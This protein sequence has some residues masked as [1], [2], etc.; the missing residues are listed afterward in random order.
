MDKKKLQFESSIVNITPINPSF[1]RAYCRI[2]Y[3]GRN[4]NGTYISKEA[5]ENAISTLY[6]VP[7]VGEWLKERDNFGGH[8]GKI[9]IHNN[10]VKYIDTTIPYGCV[11]SKEDINWRW[12]TA[13]DGREYF[14]V[15]IFLWIHKF[16]ELQKLVNENSWH[17]MEIDV[18]D[19]Q[20]RMVNGENLYVIEKMEFTALC[21]LGKDLE[22]P[23]NNTE[24]CFEMSEIGVY[25]LNKNKFKREFK[26]MI[27]EL[28]FTLSNETKEIPDYKE[29]MKNNLGFIN[30]NE[31]IIINNSK[32][33]IFCEDFDN[34][35]IE[36]NL[37]NQISK[38]NN[39]NDLL[40]EAYIVIEDDFVKSPL[41]NF[42]CQHH[43]ISGGELVIH[44][45]GLQMAFDYVKQQELIGEP[46]AHLRRHYEELGLDQDNFSEFGLNFEDY[47]KYFAKED[48]EM[49]DVIMSQSPET[50]EMEC[51]E[52]EEMACHEVA[53]PTEYVCNDEKFES[54]ADAKVDK[55]D[56]K[57]DEAEFV[58]NEEVEEDK[59]ESF[60]SDEAKAE[61]ESKAD[62]K[63]SDEKE[64]KTEEDMALKYEKLSLEHSDM[65]AKYGELSLNY[66][67]LK[68]QFSEV[69]GQ[70]KNYELKEKQSAVDAVFAEFFNL[71]TED[72]VKDVKEKA[73]NM[74]VDVLRNQLY[75][76]YGAKMYKFNLHN[77]QNQDV[78]NMGIHPVELQEKSADTESDVFA[79]AKKELENK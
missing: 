21:I 24:P 33:S 64:E 58:K 5:F 16:P 56:E 47:K 37:H 46:M 38:A 31:D 63:S 44:K 69:E 40:H 19:G 26:K 41:G 76:I 77:S 42:Q 35:K 55:E 59:K 4:R 72:D 49:E 13:E 53:E 34:S 51:V 6:Y 62:E 11:G 12:E 74:E 23:E 60:E 61:D 18:L 27:K 8:G 73:I 39:Y 28:K 14:T 17:S 68:A 45:K 57:E 32:E 66:E 52:K 20:Q 78:I 29:W 30:K 1:A 79:K 70:L 50:M 9:E 15:D 10:D 48:S 3:A 43:V 25:S 2:G 7:V 71:L 36:F 65:Q 54:E 75:S 22:E 67:N